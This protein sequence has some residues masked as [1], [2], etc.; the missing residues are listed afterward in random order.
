MAAGLALDMY[1]PS[2]GILGFIGGTVG[3]MI[4]EFVGKHLGAFAVKIQDGWKSF[5]KLFS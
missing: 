3:G 2:G 1:I 5:C 4:G